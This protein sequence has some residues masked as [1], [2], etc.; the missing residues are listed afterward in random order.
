MFSLPNK[1]DLA[2]M[3]ADVG[4]YVQR[5]L[6]VAEQGAQLYGLAKGAYQLGRAGMALA[7]YLL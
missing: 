5:G 1:G 2:R 6:H 3:S 4:R 7:P